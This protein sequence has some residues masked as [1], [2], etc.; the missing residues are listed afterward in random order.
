MYIDQLFHRWDK[1]SLFF[2][3][4]CM[5]NSRRSCHM[6]SWER[7][8]DVKIGCRNVTVY[9]RAAILEENFIGSVL[10]QRLIRKRRVNTDLL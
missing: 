4:T 9:L 5:D 10:N 3:R 2:A 8:V 6:V 1:V 7:S